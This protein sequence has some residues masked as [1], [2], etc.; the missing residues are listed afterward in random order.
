MKV[1]TAPLDKAKSLITD[2]VA[3]RAAEW[4]RRGRISHEAIEQASAAGLLCA[5]VPAEYGGLGLPWVDNGELTAHF[6]TLCGSLRSLATSQG[7]AA[8]TIQRLG[9]AAQRDEFLRKLTDGRTAAAAFS[10]PH[11]GSDLAAMRTEITLDG[12]EVVLQG[13]KAWVTGAA[14][15]DVVVVFGR[16]R[17]GSAAVVVPTSA[18]GLTIT[19]VPDPL[20]CRA[21]GHSDILLDNVRLPARHL[22][23]GAGQEIGFLVTPALTYGRLSVAW[24]CVGI[25]R[26][27]L[28]AASE[29]SRTRE[30]FGKP[31]S[32]HQLIKRH[33]AR[34]LV[35]EQTATRVSEHAARCWD[36]RSSEMARAALVAKH[37]AAGS[38]ARGAATAVQVLASAGARDSHVVARAY[39]DA[40][41]ME[42]I[43]GTDEIIELLLADEALAT[44]W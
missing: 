23:A 13:R 36:A 34:L 14:Y 25:L 38:A 20:G 9:S 39:R 12:D 35:A 28:S 18:E 21:A 15:A 17:N 30:Q 37:V 31:L 42:I 22:L 2:M 32:E 33:L 16:F 11:A 19:P 10:E 26:A 7:I 8:W 4:D 44:R 6:G 5:G 40:K 27:C 24:G 41:L 1:A 3:D 43:E 29:H